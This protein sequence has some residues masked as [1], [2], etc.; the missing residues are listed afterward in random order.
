MRETG[1]DERA[2]KAAEGL[3]TDTGLGLVLAGVAPPR[4]GRVWLV[5]TGPGDPELLTVR[6][7]R[8]IGEAD[9]IVHD[10]LVPKPILALA[11]RGAKR[12]E[13]GKLAYGPSWKQDDINAVLV[14]EAVR[15][16]RVVRLKSG[17][18]GIFG[19]LDEE[20]D[21]LDAAGVGFE[22]V[23][24]LT[25]ASAAA[26]S[27]KTSLTRRGRNSGLR[28]VTGHDVA[29]FAEQDWKALARP[30]TVAAIYMGVKAATF[31]R[32]RLM[33]HGA[34]EDTPVTAV[35]NA[36][37][38]DQRVIATTL[39]E[40]PQALDDAAPA[41]PVVLFLGLSPRAAE[42]AA[43]GSDFAENRVTA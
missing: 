1:S 8:L 38:P 31:L 29:G 28:I 10:R 21:A 43:A 41:G 30:G 26:A 33:I 25:A 20:M 42:I 12:I 39:I 40:L 5:G 18:P 11:R 13:V 14:A 27:I 7:A 37:R 23:P 16:Q 22:I 9:V 34:A 2:E 3:G 32:G 4:Q 6:A 35:E 15:G 36:S 19:R 17:D 24:G